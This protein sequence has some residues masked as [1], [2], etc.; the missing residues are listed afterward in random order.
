MEKNVGE[1]MDFLSSPLL[2]ETNVPSSQEPKTLVEIGESSE[3]PLNSQNE[4]NPTMQLPIPPTDEENEEYPKPIIMIVHAGE[5][6]VS[7]ILEYARDRDVSILVNHASGPIS[8]VHLTNPLN[9]D[10]D[11]IF[12]GNLHM[13]CLS[14]VYTKCLAPS[15]PKNVPFS[16]FNVQFSRGEAPE[17][18][19]GLVGSRLIA[20]Q[21]VQVAASIFK[22]HDYY[23]YRGNRS[24]GP[25]F[26]PSIVNN[27][28]NATT[29][30]TTINNIVEQRGMFTAESA[31]SP[32]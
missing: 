13:F 27:D 9:R 4:P 12:Q 7:T 2:G 15:P 17:I 20:A 18:Y 32:M 10:Y 14:G 5:D 22:E 31:S 11:C 1:F 6:I 21:A 3:G 8:E 19:G 29:T 25:S 24:S 16:F 23:E 26:Y 30:T 28:P